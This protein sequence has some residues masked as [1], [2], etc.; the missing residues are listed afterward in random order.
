M[1]TFMNTA[2]VGTA[3]QGVCTAELSFQNALVYAKD[4]LSMRSLSG[5]KAPDKVADPIINHPDVRR[6]LLTQKAF[7][8]G[9]RAMIYYTSKIVD[10]MSYSASEKERAEAEDKLGF[11]TPI[12][13]AFLT[14]S[15][16]ESANLGVQIFG[17]HGYIKEWGMEQIVRDARISTLYEGTTGIQALDLLGRKILLGRGKTLKAFAKEVLMF[18]KDN[19]M[20]SDN[21]QKKRMHKFIWPLSKEIAL[22]QSYTLRLALKIKKDRDVLG[23]ASVDYLMYSGYVMM[24]YFWAMMAQKANEKLTEGTGNKAFYTAKV[25]TAEFYFSRILPRTRAHAKS[26]MASPKSLMQLKEEDFSFL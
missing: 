1:F 16:C 19:S 20:L 18:C 10:D 22:W 9:G 13:K 15:G 4:R 17:G 25:K 2:R 8:E 6:M 14:E 11:I 24:A 7:A 26:M 23:S 21:V 3:M 5:T 12:L